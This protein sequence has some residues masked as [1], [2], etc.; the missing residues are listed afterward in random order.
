MMKIEKFIQK[1]NLQDSLLEEVEYNKEKKI[2]R[3]TIDF[4]YWQ[5][6][7]YTEDVPETGDISIEFQEVDELCYESY[8]I[9]SD[10]IVSASLEGNKLELMVFND[11]LGEYKKIAISAKD[12]NVYEN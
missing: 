1:Y 4:C 9:N 11:V 6:E 7:N 8:P 3:L 10:E 12:V 5:Q 2:A